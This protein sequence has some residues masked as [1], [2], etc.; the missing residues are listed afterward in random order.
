VITLIFA[1]DGSALTIRLMDQS[2][3]EIDVPTGKIIRT[4]K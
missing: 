4:K 3:I 2:T 1:P